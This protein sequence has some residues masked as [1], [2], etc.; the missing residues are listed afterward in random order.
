LVEIR[1]K[2]GITTRY[3]HLSRFA[4]GMRAGTKVTQGQTIGYVGMTGL[5]NG[6]HLHYELRQ[7]GQP[8]NPFAVD[9]GNG[10]PIGDEEREEFDVRRQQLEQDLYTPPQ[11]FAQA[12][13]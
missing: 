3:A 12:G 7:N 11:S 10:D 9:F 2:N 5:A 4:K 8:R 1:H 6:P 13:E